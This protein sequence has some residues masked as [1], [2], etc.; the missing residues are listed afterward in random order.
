MEYGVSIPR[1]GRATTLVFGWAP[2]YAHF[3]Y[4]AI[5]SHF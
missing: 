2:A 3:P 4:A 5:S 1:A